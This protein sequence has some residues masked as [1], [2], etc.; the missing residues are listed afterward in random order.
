MASS[1]E[2]LDILIDQVVLA[3]RA[4][5]PSA[6]PP[7]EIV[8][9]VR[10]MGTLTALQPV[11]SPQPVL[12]HQ[13]EAPILRIGSDA[14]H[15][16]ASESELIEEPRRP[17]H[18]RL[19][20]TERTTPSAPSQVKSSKG[21]LQRCAASLIAFVISR[22]LI[23]GSGLHRAFVVGIVLSAG[24]LSAVHAAG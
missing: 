12:V 11:G 24:I 20:E 13:H 16:S 21:F 7:A 5:K 19:Y 4:Q 1:P 15:S 18:E 3:M 23:V 14:Q 6:E 9:R 8:D 10:Q 22:W 2:A 17:V